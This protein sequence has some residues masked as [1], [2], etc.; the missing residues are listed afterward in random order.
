[1]PKKSE[2]PKF[3]PDGIECNAICRNVYDG[4]TIYLEIDLRNILKKY[5]NQERYG[6]IEQLPYR[7]V[8]FLCRMAGYNSAEISRSSEEEKHKG[9][10][11]KDFLSEL[12]LDK[13]LKV[14]FLAS[15]EGELI[16]LTNHDPYGRPIID[17][18]TL[19]GVYVNK[20]MIESGHGKPYNGRGEKK[21]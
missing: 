12:I 2:F 4:D 8:Y 3:S 19:E 15:H 14:H 7:P 5:Y 18:Y 9:L 6:I 21:Y 1:M 13:E 20:L 11:A 10:E 17:L 16:Q